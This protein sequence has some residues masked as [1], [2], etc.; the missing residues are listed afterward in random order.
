[1][2]PSEGA[3]RD[4]RKEGKKVVKRAE[5]LQSALKGSYY[6]ASY[7]AAS[8][9]AP[10]EVGAAPINQIIVASAALSARCALQVHHQMVLITGAH[11]GSHWHL[12]EVR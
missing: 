8:I 1:M 6:T 7:T 12:V 9:A 3:G 2:N 10:S 5:T 11:V 4:V